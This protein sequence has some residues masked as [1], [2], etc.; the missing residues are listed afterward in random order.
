M[1]TKKKPPQDYDVGYGKPPKH[2]RFK[3]GQSGNPR[4]RKKKEICPNNI[5]RG[6]LE[7]KISIRDANG[8]RSVT[9]LE[10]LIRRLLKDSFA[11]KVASTRAL[12]PM[13]TTAFDRS[14]LKAAQDDVASDLLAEEDHQILSRLLYAECEPDKDEK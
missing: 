11:G 13:L 8:S 7:E 6:V 2:S 3:P 12:L 9:N 10:A 14:E 4:G 5:V 1:T